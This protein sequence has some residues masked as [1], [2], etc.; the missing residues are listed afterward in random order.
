MKKLLVAVLLL[1]VFAM[2][3][4]VPTTQPEIPQPEVVGGEKSSTIKLSTETMTVNVG[5]TVYLPTAVAVDG[6]GKDITNRVMVE[7]LSPDGTQYIP[8]VSYFPMSFSTVESGNYVARYTIYGDNSTVVT[9]KYAVIT[10]RI[11]TVAEGFVIDG[12]L[13]ELQYSEMPSY[14]SGLNSN[15][16]VQSYFDDNGVYLGVDVKDSNL[17][18][19][20]YVVG[21][22]TQT[23][24][25][26]LY[27]DF[28]NGSSVL[29]NDLC[30]KLEV[31]VNGDVWISKAKQSK[32][33]FELQE[34]LQPQY[35]LQLHGTK[36]VVDSSDLKPYRDEDEG[37]TFEVYLPY[38]VL[39]VSAKPQQVGFAL[40]HRDVSS[41]YSDEIQDGS[42]YNMCYNE[43]Q[44]PKNMTQE[45]FD[46]GNNYTLQWYDAYSLTALYNT[47]YVEGNK[48]IATTQVEPVAT[49]DGQATDEIYNNATEVSIGKATVKAVSDSSGVYIFAT[50]TS[51][52]LT[53]AVASNEQH[54]ST[55]LGNDYKQDGKRIEFVDGG[56]YISSLSKSANKFV[57]GIDRQI[58]VRQSDG[59]VYIE[60]FIPHY[61]IGQ[62]SWFICV[63]DGEV[64]SCNI[65]NPSLYTAIAEVNS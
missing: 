48:G 5:Q 65:D 26:A 25:F 43:V 30:Y 53:V 23:D 24:G 39:G 62:G 1:L 2:S 46:N 21:R 9:R 50:T 49:I 42:Q 35:R 57:M 22:F 28:A 59:T 38:S 15:V 34:S 33:G 11:N 36:T 13:N 44:L 18:Y 58:A 19:N 55:Q 60:I 31:N 45:V 7:V 47:L 51:G 54:G 29:L 41:M 14:I 3:G 16:V 56:L 52:N 64:F 37:Y 17:I 12:V 40:S 6:D 32:V 8:E 20:D 61:E 4:C 63:G 27:M 10:S